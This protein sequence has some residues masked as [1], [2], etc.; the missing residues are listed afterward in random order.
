MYQDV[1]LIRTHEI[2]LRLNDKEAALIEAFAAYTGGQ[3]AA[4]V[5]ELI[6]SGITDL[7]KNSE[8]QAQ[9]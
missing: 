7:M 9:K 8:V 2:K 6:L 5:R 4:L 3:K 1:A